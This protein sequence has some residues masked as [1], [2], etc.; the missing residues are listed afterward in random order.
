MKSNVNNQ[1]KSN[2]KYVFILLLTTVFFTSLQFIFNWVTKVD[3]S[4][5]EKDFIEIYTFIVSVLSLF[6]VYFAIIQFSLQMKGDKNI[7][8]GIDYVSYLQKSSQ[9]YQFST[10][11][12]FFTSL[13]LFVTLPIISKLGFLSVLLEKI[14]NSICL[15]LICLFIL[16]LYKGLNQILEITDENKTKKQ[17]IIYNEKVKKINELLQLLYNKNYEGMPEISKIQYFFMHIKYEINIIIKSNSMDSEFEKQYYL[18]C[19]LYLLDAKGKI[20]PK[21]IVYFLREYLKLLDEYEIELLFKSKESQSKEPRIYYCPL[22]DEFTSMHKKIE[23]ND[24]LNEYIDE[25]YDFLKKQ[26][27]INSPFLIQFVLDNPY[28]FL[29]VELYQ[30]KKFLDLIIALSSFDIQELEYQLFNLG[31]SKDFVESDISKLVCKVWNYLFEKYDQGAI[32][33]L[34]P[35]ENHFEFQSFFGT[36]TE[37]IY[38]ENWYSKALGD[39]VEK[40]PESELQDCILK[41]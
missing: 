10:S 6:G 13:F 11:N 25:L 34:F 2:W 28:L 38:E 18:N 5:L 41:I 40:N 30:L 31:K 14:W 26:K 21:K 16:L 33:L 12:T 20:S 1:P 32:D 23:N 27:Y 17:D 36:K 24:N 15:F 19:L 3:F 7:Y 29:K 8:F 4:V 9:I 37:F 39:Y 35:V 22:L